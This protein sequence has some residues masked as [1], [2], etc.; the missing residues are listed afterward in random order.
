MDA[1]RRSTALNAY[2]AGL[3]PTKRVVLYDTLIDDA[4]RPE[5]ESVVAHELGH[6]AHSDIPRGIAF[7]ALVTPLGPAARPRA[8]GRAGAP[9]RRGARLARG[10]PRA[11][12]GDRGDRFAR[13][14]PGQPALAQGRGQRRRVRAADHRRPARADRAADAG[15]RSATSPTRIRPRSPRSCSAPI[16]RRSS[17]SARRWRGSGASARLSGSSPSRAQ[18]AVRARPSSSSTSAR[19][20]SSSAARPDAIA[21]RCTSPGAGGAISGSNSAS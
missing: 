17:G 18:R 10:G 11:V 15:W 21:I 4:E 6:V 12:P 5:L 9:R 2:V 19:Q 14:R 1:S 13:Q 8:V 7:A 20:P 16:R 3:G